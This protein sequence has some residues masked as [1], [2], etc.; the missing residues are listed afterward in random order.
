MDTWFSQYQP[1]GIFDQTH[2][3]ILEFDTLSPNEQTAQ[4]SEPVTPTYTW[5]DND[6]VPNPDDYEQTKF[7]RSCCLFSYCTLANIFVQS[8]RKNAGVEL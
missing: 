4:P 7:R 5:D 3:S 8:R 6:L 1:L 2:P